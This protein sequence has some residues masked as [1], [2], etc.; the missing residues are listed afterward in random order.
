MQINNDLFL[1]VKPSLFYYYILVGVKFIYLE[2]I[3][4]KEF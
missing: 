2:Y 3:K 1:L 4:W